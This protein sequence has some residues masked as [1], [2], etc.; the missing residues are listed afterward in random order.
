M[1][2]GKVILWRAGGCKLMAGDHIHSQMAR[3]AKGPVEY[4]IQGGG[5]VVLVCHGT[6]SN[7]FSTESQGPLVDAGFR[8]LTP[9]RPGYG[10]TPSSTGADNLRAAEAMIA[11][12]DTLQ[13]STCSVVA[14]SGGGPTGI[15]LAANHPERVERLVLLAAISHTEGRAAEPAFESQKA[16]YGPLH[17]A[18]WGM[19]RLSSNLSPRSMAKQTLTLFSTHDAED[20]LRRLTREDVESIRRFYQGASSRQGALNDLTHSVDLELIHRVHQRTLVIHSREDRSVPFHHAE[21]SVQNIRNSELCEAG[22]TG[23]FFW[24]GPEFPTISQRLVD[25]L[26]AGMDKMETSLDL[27]QSL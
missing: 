26:R 4:T 2:M 24:I 6:S 1:I 27:Q 15:T 12:L 21:W 17:P 18:I 9:S 22:F 8:V 16:F 3:T 10:Q 25:F 14:I 13:I 7:C 20:G 11:L 23:H 5:P 19:L